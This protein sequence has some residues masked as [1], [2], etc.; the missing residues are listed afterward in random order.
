MTL[1]FLMLASLKRALS[2]SS[3]LLATLSLSLPTSFPF[4]D[5]RCKK[6]IASHLA[7]FSSDFLLFYLSSLG[8]KKRSRGEGIDQRENEKLRFYSER[9][10]KFLALNV[11]LTKQ[12]AI[13]MSLL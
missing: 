3:S 13:C 6:A 7:P 11:A 9:Y 4:S 2:S 10:R 1:L 12:T 8:K 5:E